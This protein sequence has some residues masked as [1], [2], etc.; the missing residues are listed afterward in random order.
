MTERVLREFRNFGQMR[1]C[2]VEAFGEPLDS[3]DSESTLWVEREE[4]RYGALN[5]KEPF[6]ILC[7]KDWDRGV[8]IQNHSPTEE[9]SQTVNNLNVRF[10]KYEKNE[11]HEECETL[12]RWM[13]TH[14]LEGHFEKKLDRL[15]KLMTL[16]GSDWLMQ[17]PEHI[18]EVAFSLDCDGQDHELFFPKTEGE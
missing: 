14:L 4:D 16:I 8:V 10:T 9:V 2:W 12:Y 5:M 11:P 6:C 15:A 1:A 3:Y 17:H 13:A 7:K 18:A